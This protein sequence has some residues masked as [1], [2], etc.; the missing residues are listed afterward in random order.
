MC[1][2]ILVFGTSKSQTGTFKFKCGTLGLQLDT[3]ELQFGILGV[4][5]ANFNDYGFYFNAFFNFFSC[6]SFEAFIP[7][8]IV[9]AFSIAPPN[10]VCV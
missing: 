5:L 6:L 9:L 8:A 4:Q 2:F 1:L 7:S 10:A 3:F